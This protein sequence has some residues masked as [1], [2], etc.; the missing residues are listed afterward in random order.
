MT[1]RVTITNEGGLKKVTTT[2]AGSKE[3][4]DVT[5]LDSSGADAATQIIAQLNNLV[6]FEIA[7][8]DFIKVTRVP[9]GDGKGKIQTVTIRTGG[10]SGT[11]VATLTLTYDTSGRFESVTK[12]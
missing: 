8:N 10:S 4:L 6:G 9:A 12:T 11:V 1:E 7:P 2:T 5:I 3:T